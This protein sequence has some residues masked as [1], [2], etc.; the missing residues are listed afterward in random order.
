MNLDRLRC[1][2]FGHPPKPVLKFWGGPYGMT[3]YCR[4]CGDQL[5][6]R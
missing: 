3:L 6:D 4:R 2:L 5:K 1:S